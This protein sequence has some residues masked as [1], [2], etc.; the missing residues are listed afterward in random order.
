MFPV[1][2]PFAALVAL[3]AAHPPKAFAGT[4]AVGCGSYTTALPSGDNGPNANPDMPFVT[5]SFNQVPTS[6][7]WWETFLWK[8]AP[9]AEL[10]GQM[11]PLPW[12]IEPHAGGLGMAF[13]TVANVSVGNVDYPYTEDFTAGLAGLNA[14]ATRVDS[15][16]DWEVTAEWND[17]TNVLDVSLGNGFPFAY[18]ERKAG[19]DARVS[20]SGTPTV[21][22]N[23]NGVLVATVN[24]H[25]YAFY[26][27]SGSGWTQAGNV[28]TNPL[29]G[30]LG[31]GYFSVAV[32]PD[33]SAATQALYLGSAYAFVTSTAVSWNYDQAT[34]DLTSTFTVSVR[35][36]E[37]GQATA[38]QAL[39][40]H[41]WINSAAALTGLSYWGPNAGPRGEMKVLRGNQFST[42][43]KF[44]G[45]LP[46]LPDDGSSDSATLRSYVDC[47]YQNLVT[48]NSNGG[49]GNILDGVTDTYDEGHALVKAADLAWLADQVGDTAARQAFI[50]AV[51][52]MLQQW[53]NGAAATGTNPLFHYD[54]IWHSLIGYP[55]GFGADT[56]LNDHHFHY[57]YW[58]RAMATVAHFDPAW[59]NGCFHGM[60][61]MLVGDVANADRSSTQYPFLRAFSPYQGHSWA[62]GSDGNNEESSSEDIQLDSALIQLGSETGN[63]AMRDLGIFMY[64][65][66]VQGIEQYWFDVDNQVFPPGYQK[67]CVG[68]VWEHGYN[69]GTYF[70]GDPSAAVGIQLIPEYA[71]AAAYL[72]RNPA[73]LQAMVNQMGETTLN[74]L[75]PE[76]FI[77]AEALYNPA[78]AVT[79]FNYFLMSGDPEGASE[80]KAH[81]Y[82]WVQFFNCAGRLD[83]GVT[84]D[85]PDTNVFINGSG[86]KTYC[87]ENP[88]GSPLTVHF[89]DGYSMTLAPGAL[90]AAG[91]LCGV[92]PTDSASPTPSAS[93]SPSPRAT[94]TATTGLTGTATPTPSTTASPSPRAT[95][96]ATMGLTGTATPTPSASASPSA[97]ATETATMGLT[98]TATPTPSTTAS[99]T[100]AISATTDATAGTVTPPAN[101]AGPAGG[102]SGGGLVE[103]VVPVPNPQSGPWLGLEVRLL[104][105]TQSLRIVVYDEAFVKVAEG[106]VQSE[107]RQGWNPLKVYAPG[108]DNGLYY[109]L[110]LGPD[111]LAQRQGG[112][113]KLWMAR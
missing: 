34:A 7:Q 49:C 33:L 11:T 66:T 81:D 71:G 55:S 106:V 43:E 110:C 50:T 10:G 77:M 68:Q 32:L 36:M 26:G 12:W 102:E 83:T 88:T 60:A 54:S 63:T 6:N 15:Y 22:S 4:V 72:G 19:G 45:L 94:E 16:S 24:N 73:H 107:C 70:S 28:F 64:C 37:Q 96:T 113:A 82:H 30:A 90:S 95:E 59:W 108:L 31:S 103:Q 53:Y 48:P 101:Q 20:F 13:E 100:P 23:S 52:N 62:G 27:P 74:T 89:S 99:P 87:A 109:V 1:R 111:G 3:M 5:S 65:N 56:N 78:Q 44:N 76:I 46:A 93:A 80:S 98:G 9:T 112:P 29:A 97:R 25:D 38:L 41:Q 51:E 2:F 84:A 21:V 58:I 8:T 67:L 105:R 75:Y 61:N 92:T 69:Y 104:G 85:W 42:V 86:G 17:G 39:F 14:T 35:A 40:R 18:F 47:S 79:D 57:G 91:A